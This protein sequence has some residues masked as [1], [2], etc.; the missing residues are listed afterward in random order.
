MHPTEVTTPHK[1]KCE[2]YNSTCATQPGGC[3]PVTYCDQHGESQKH[4]C[5]VVWTIEPNGSTTV[6]LKVIYKYFVISL[7]Y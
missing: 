6:S 1:T 3:E 4:Q 2:F 5:F 7:S